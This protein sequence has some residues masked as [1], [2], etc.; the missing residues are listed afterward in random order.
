M[1][2]SVQT[3][4]EAKNEALNRFVFIQKPNIFHLS[5]AIDTI[6]KSVLLMQN[7]YWIYYQYSRARPK[8]GT[9]Q[10]VLAT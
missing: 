6:T 5:T 2:I 9:H 8:N 3:F 10:L 4:N 1:C 7:F